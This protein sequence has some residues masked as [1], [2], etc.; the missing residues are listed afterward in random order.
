MNHS[1]HALEDIRRM[2]L[3]PKCSEQDRN[4][5]FQVA[6][7]LVSGVKFLLPE[8]GAVGVL[9]NDAKTQQFVRCPFPVTVFEWTMDPGR[10][11][12]QDG[13]YEKQLG[14]PTSAL[15]PC[16]KR[17]AI[18]CEAKLV[19]E[20]SPGSPEDLIAI[21]SIYFDETSKGWIV[22]PLVTGVSPSTSNFFTL[23]GSSAQEVYT[24]V[25]LPGVLNSIAKDIG[26]E[27][28]IKQ[29]SLDANDEV[30]VALNAMACVNAK[31]VSHI[32]VPAPAALNKKRARTGKA[33][34][35]EYKVLDIFLGPEVRA[36]ASS[37]GKRYR[38]ALEAWMKCGTKL[39]VV[40]GHFKT[41]KTGIFWWNSYMRGSQNKGV[42]T[43]DYSITTT[44]NN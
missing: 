7:L 9:V 29:S 32:T 36:T 43:K 2:L 26:L 11:L 22:N 28:A 8:N 38:A 1:T 20:V 21:Y 34:F 41:R 31:N 37:G 35:F 15:T 24:W 33:P 18:A 30:N 13:R 19:V 14:L 23:N 12:D 42:V 5:L 6:G 39:H 10:Q 44:G 25:L 40:R 16:L 3:S 17:I 27:R 4:G